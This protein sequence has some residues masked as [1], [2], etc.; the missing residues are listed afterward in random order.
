MVNNKYYL[1]RFLKTTKNVCTL[2]LLYSFNILIF[3]YLHQ[4]QVIQNMV[5]VLIKELKKIMYAP[6]Q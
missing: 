6:K 3:K 5:D 2:I 4:K 1:L